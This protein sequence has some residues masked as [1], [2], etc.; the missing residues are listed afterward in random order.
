MTSQYA[1][2]YGAIATHMAKPF[3]DR[4]GSGGHVHYHLADATTG[5]N[6]LMDES[7]PQGLGLSEMGYHFIG[8]VLKHAPALCAI[9]SPTINCYKRLQ[10]GQGLYSSRSGFTWTPAFITFGDNN[11]T[12]MIR[13]AG[14]GHL[15]D[16][17]ISAANNPY[18]VFAAYV[19]AGLDGIKNKI[20]PGTPNMGNN[21]YE[22]GLDEIARRGIRM[23]PQS[24][25]EALDELKKDPVIQG[26]LG[27]ISDEFIRL[28]EAEYQDYHSQVTQWEIDR[29]LT[30]F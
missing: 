25:P 8:G 18:L 13:T 24:L 11:R 29:Y 16:R 27:V 21:M 3:S 15:E 7:D 5:E 28:K 17:T 6:V 4:T 10:V 9:N 1:K 19:T 22:L 2:R 14:P 12:Q 30:M 26:A 20:D 23:L